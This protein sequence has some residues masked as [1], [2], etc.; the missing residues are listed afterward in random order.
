MTQQ[1]SHFKV[2]TEDNGRQNLKRFSEM[3]LGK[4]V[5]CC[6]LAFSAS[7]AEARKAKSKVSSML[8]RL[9]EHKYEGKTL[10]I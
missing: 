9:S 4:L 6:L 2:S 3:L 7:P 1:I 5:A 10:N 8:Q